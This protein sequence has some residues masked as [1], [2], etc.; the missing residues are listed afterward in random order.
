MV[1]KAKAIK[2]NFT[3]NGGL[4]VKKHKFSDAD[5]RGE[6][7]SAKRNLE[8]YYKDL[9]AY[10]EAYGL[11]LKFAAGDDVTTTLVVYPYSK[12]TNDDG[13][14]V[15]N[16]DQYLISARSAYAAAAVDFASKIEMSFQPAYV[17]AT[18]GR[19]YPARYAAVADGGYRWEVNTTYT[20]EAVNEM[21]AEYGVYGWESRIESGWKILGEK[22]I[23]EKRLR[24]EE[25]TFRRCGVAVIPA[26]KS[27]VA[28]S[29][30][31]DI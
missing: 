26:T 2:A 4:G 16:S 11:V 6:V 15:L 7:K 30:I 18:D 1:I 8:A 23:T 3:N 20:L 13:S 24:G 5:F 25:F 31:A 19:K 12:S 28:D 10:A 27:T 22:A 14:P 21:I 9:P 29:D 17:E